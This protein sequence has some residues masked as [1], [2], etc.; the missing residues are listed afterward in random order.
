MSGKLFHRAITILASIVV[1]A[2]PAAAEDPVSGFEIYGPGELT[3]RVVSEDG[4]TLANVEVHVTSKSGGDRIVKSD[5]QGNYK[6]K[7]KAGRDEASFVFVRDPHARVEGKLAL[8]VTIDG[9]EAIEIHESLPPAVMA[10]PRDAWAAIPEYSKVAIDKDVWTKAWLLLD[11]SASGEVTQL[12]LLK[13]AGYD[14]DPIAIREGFKLKFEPARDRTKHAIRSQLVWGFEWP[15]RSWLLGKGRSLYRMPA[16]VKTVPCRST[17]GA[18]R[19]QHR[20]CANADLGKGLS[21]NWLVA[22]RPP[23]QR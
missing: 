7:L 4:K 16:E 12:K 22:P 6:L 23:A 5:K 3:G 11:V 18:F 17:T 8:S 14:L 15:S 20:D 9:N 19:P 2:S 1:L 10:K 13:R 21:E